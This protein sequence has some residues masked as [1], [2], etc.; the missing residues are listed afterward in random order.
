MR[1]KILILILSITINLIAVSRAQEYRAEAI[2]E[3]DTILIGDQIALDLKFFTP[4]DALIMWPFYQDTI[5]RDIELISKSMIDSSRTDNQLLITQQ[6]T[7]TS[8]DSG[9]HVIPPITFGYRKQD[10]STGKYS[11]TNP[12]YLTVMTITVDTTQAIKPIKGPIEARVTFSEMLPW[13]LGGLG[14]VIVVLVLLYVF[15]WRKSPEKLPWVRQK[16]KLPAHIIALNDLEKLKKLKLWQA[17][18]Y[19]DYYTG[20]TDILRIYME[21]RFGMQAMEMTTDEIIDHLKQDQIDDSL[22]RS[23]NHLLSLADLVKFAKEEP[24][25]TDNDSSYKAAEGFVKQTIIVPEAEEPEEGPSDLMINPDEK[26]IVVE[27][28]TMIENDVKNK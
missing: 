14:L 28:E 26:E 19:K 13:L 15:I 1:L 8:F 17:G 21:E 24:L 6:L 2:L 12:L 5:T 11:Q 4:P 25:P 7:I 18:K 16:P 22:K 20:L 9:L 3:N 10:D 27:E 23:L